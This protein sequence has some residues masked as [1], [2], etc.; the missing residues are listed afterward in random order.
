LPVLK[1]LPFSLSLF[2]KA[3][4]P[5][6]AKLSYILAPALGIATKEMKSYKIAHEKILI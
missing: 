1:N 6:A 3:Q 4:V 5:F 2:S